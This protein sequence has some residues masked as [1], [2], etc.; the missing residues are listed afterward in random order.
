MSSTTVR[1]FIPPFRKAAFLTPPSSASTSF[2]DAGK[3]ILNVDSDE[4]IDVVV[5]STLRVISGIVYHTSATSGNEL[6]DV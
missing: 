1:V 4:A 6:K 5:S 3:T 2:Y